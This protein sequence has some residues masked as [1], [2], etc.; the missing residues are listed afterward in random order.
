MIDV[1]AQRQTLC[2]VLLR[3]SMSHLGE[4]R[5]YL[6]NLV[7]VCAFSTLAFRFIMLDKKIV[8]PKRG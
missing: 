2:F 6:L 4:Y 5:K 8:R 7:S 1:D 3:D